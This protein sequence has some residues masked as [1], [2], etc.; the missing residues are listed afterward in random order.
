MALSLIY[1]AL[2]L[3]LVQTRFTM[4]DKDG[5][6]SFHPVLFCRVVS[7]RHVST[8]IHSFIPLSLT[9]TTC[10]N[11]KVVVK[12]NQGGKVVEEKKGKSLPSSVPICL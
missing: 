6:I 12:K 2:V 9:T 4:T 5:G 1:Q 8:H 3:S 7:C 10:H 11:G